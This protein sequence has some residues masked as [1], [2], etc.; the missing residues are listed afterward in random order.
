M[1]S[2]RCLWCANWLILYMLYINDFQAQRS[3]SISTL[4]PNWPLT[5][6]HLRN[7]KET[8]HEKASARKNTPSKMWLA[9]EFIFRIPIRGKKGRRERRTRLIMKPCRLRPLQI[10][11][12]PWTPGGGVVK[13]GSPVIAG[14]QRLRRKD[15]SQKNN[16]C[17][18]E[19]RACV[20]RARSRLIIVVAIVFGMC[21]DCVSR[22]WEA[23][24]RDYLVEKLREILRFMPG[25]WV[26]GL[27]LLLE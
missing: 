25:N 3:R 4:S 16:A 19:G 21:I 20:T 1:D 5:P 18:K 22:F 24:F 26:I 11:H 6:N 12:S 17:W 13:N 2:I 7:L 27:S 8:S 10:F 23:L 15:L 9:L 14:P